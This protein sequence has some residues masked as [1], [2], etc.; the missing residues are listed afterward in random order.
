MDIL[1]IAIEAEGSV[2]KLAYVLGVSPTAISNWRNPERGLPL[3]WKTA[4]ALKYRKQIKAAAPITPRPQS[5]R[6]TA[7]A[8]TAG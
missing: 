5:K 1:E 6:T 4:I 8:A 7:S 3:S 2:G